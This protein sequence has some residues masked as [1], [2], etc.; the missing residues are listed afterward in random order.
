M[1]QL[2]DDAALARLGQIAD[3]AASTMRTTVADPLYRRGAASVLATRLCG[4]CGICCLDMDSVNLEV[5]RRAVAWVE[6][7]IP[8]TLATVVKTWGS[9]PRTEGGTLGHQ[10]RRAVGRF[11]LRGCIE[12]DLLIRLR[13]AQPQRP[14]LLVYGVTAEQTRRF[15]LPCGG[16]LQLVLEP[17][18]SRQR[19]ASGAGCGASGLVGGTPTGFAR[20]QH[21]FAA[22]V[23]DTAIVLTGRPWFRLS[24]RAGACSSSAAGSLRITWLQFALALDYQVIPER[25]TQEEYR[26]SW[27]LPQVTVRSDMPDVWCNFSSRIGAPS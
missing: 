24:D 22:A 25:A 11:R 2:L 14:E 3:M 21:A 8:A 10:R 19:S 1:G 20:W 7:G 23:P 6:A 15:G 12:D 4:S 5:L 16:T 13:A 27:S 17:F 9:A 18:D 26:A